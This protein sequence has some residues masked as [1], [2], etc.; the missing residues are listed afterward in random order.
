MR[1]KTGETPEKLGTQTSTEATDIRIPVDVPITSDPIIRGAYRYYILV[2][3]NSS[4]FFD[5]VK[6][7]YRE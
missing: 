4:S 7:V 1:T 6:I 5:R 2:S 3:V